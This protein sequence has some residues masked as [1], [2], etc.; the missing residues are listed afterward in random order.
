MAA[1]AVRDFGSE[2]TRALL[3]RP[4][5]AN[6][7][8]TRIGSAIPNVLAIA[9]A[10][11]VRRLLTLGVVKNW[12]ASGECRALVNMT[13]QTI[14]TG[15]PVSNALPVNPTQLM[16]LV[17]DLPANLPI[18]STR[19][20]GLDAA[21]NAMTSVRI[22]ALTVP[23]PHVPTNPLAVPGSVFADDRAH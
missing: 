5:F 17:P 16:R 3:R 23:R 19:D 14:C 15:L 20:I 11:G 2:M 9:S 8:A 1:Q 22:S 21:M 12:A 13:A 6:V 7:M 18:P 10:W 4:D